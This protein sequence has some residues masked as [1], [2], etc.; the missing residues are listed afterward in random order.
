M[1][2]F[3]TRAT[4]LRIATAAAPSTFADYTAEISKATITS[5]ESD[6]DFT[7]FADAAAGGAR[8]YF[9]ELTIAQDPAS[10]A[11]YQ[12]LWSAEV[13]TDCPFELWPN[14]RPVSGTA[15]ATQP[16]Y[17]GTCTISEPDGDFLGG[18]A[19]KSNTAK[20]ATEVSWKLLAKPTKTIS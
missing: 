3:G 14:G 11:L 17:S 12:K 6:A 16:K 5:G 4:V 15:S 2:A 18:E 9:L 1:T 10:T 19:D 13:G 8:E 20:F 7:T